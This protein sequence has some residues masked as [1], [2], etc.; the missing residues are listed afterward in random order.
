MLRWINFILS[1]TFQALRI[2]EEAAIKLISKID[3]KKKEKEM[4]KER[5]EMEQ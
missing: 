5:K 4:E 3:Y 1:K 2:K